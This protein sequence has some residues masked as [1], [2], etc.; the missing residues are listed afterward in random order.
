MFPEFS[1]SRVLL[2]KIL[3]SDQQKIFEGLSH[4]EVVRYYGISFST[5]EQ[6]SEQMMWFE[7]LVKT[8]T[9]I[10]WAICSRDAQVFYG[11]CGFNHL[12]QEHRK[13]E[14]GF[15]LLP[16]FWGKGIMIEALPLIIKYAFTQLKLHRIEGFVE[17]NNLSSKQLLGRLHFR[18]EATLRECEIK[19]GQYIS[20]DIY[21][22]LHP[23]C[24]GANV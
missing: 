21:A 11:A 8:G 1:T 19:N 16:P 5:F 7:N 22:K 14:I 17:S 15:W 18:H 13:A 24:Y 20:L 6:A 10:W 4:P 23:S 9:G 3:S 12:V 2:R